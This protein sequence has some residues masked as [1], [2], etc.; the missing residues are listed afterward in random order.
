MK[1][2]TA[3]QLQQ[4][5]DVVRIAVYTNFNCT[6]AEY[7]QVDSLKRTHPDKFFFVNSN[8][9]TPNLITLNNHRDLK[10]VITINPDLIV[11]EDE[12]CRF[13]EVNPKQVAFV[14]VKYLPENEAIT[15]LITELH[16]DHYNV[17]VTLQKFIR[18]DN[19]QH[20]SDRRHY[21]QSCT[22]FRLSGEA[23]SKVHALVDSFDPPTVYICDR[24][25]L[26]CS[27]C[28]LCSIL[29]T[30]QRLKISS[31][32][33]SSSGN[34]PFYCP[35]CYAQALLVRVKQFRFDSIKRNDKQTGKTV[36]IQRALATA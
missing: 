24:N 32:D 6:D 33:L 11:R 27:G 20:Y 21:E 35:D 5:Q 14:R 1:S 16:A 9:K 34:C 25:N 18:K 17:V 2:E 13:Y 10:A 8:V 4:Y 30:G 15:N 28:Q 3:P 22:R 7:A 29:T 19:M 36:H 12:L 23:L 26:G 31:L